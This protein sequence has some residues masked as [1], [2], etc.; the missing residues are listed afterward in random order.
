MKFQILMQEEHAKGRAEGHAEG[1]LSSLIGL[2]KNM[3][4]SA[5]KALQLLDVPEIEW[6]TYLDLLAKENEEQ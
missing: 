1:R 6:A 2:M 3:N 5:E 4:C